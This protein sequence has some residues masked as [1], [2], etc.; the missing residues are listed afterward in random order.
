MVSSTQPDYFT[1]TRC[2]LI[3]NYAELLTIVFA[4][5]DFYESQSIDLHIMPPYEVQQSYLSNFRRRLYDMMIQATRS[6]QEM[7]VL[8]AEQVVWQQLEEQLL[9]LFST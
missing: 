2:Q 9:H 1:P 6:G 4:D 5:E 8:Q 7:T 3:E